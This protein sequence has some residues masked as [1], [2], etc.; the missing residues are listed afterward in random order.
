MKYSMFTVKIDYNNID[1]GVLLINEVG[2]TSSN[3]L[4]SGLN[5]ID[6]QSYYTR[7]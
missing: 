2:F 5:M 6:K 4:F 3:G 7:Y 1:F